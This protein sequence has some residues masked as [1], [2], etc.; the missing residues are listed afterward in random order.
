MC[1]FRQKISF[2]FFKNIFDNHFK[3]SWGLLK[4]Y[5]GFHLVG[6]DGDEYSLSATGDA[7]AQEYRGR[8]VHGDKETYYPR[9]YAVKAIHLLSGVVCGFHHS[10][11]NDEISGALEILENLPKKTIAVYDRFYLSK[12]LLQAHKDHGSHFIFRCK[13]GATFKEIIDFSASSKRA[14]D[15]VLEGINIR[16]IKIKIPGTKK[17]LIFATNLPKENWS[18]KKIEEIYQLRWEC[19][20][21]N[22]DH[23]LSM[24]MEAFH[25]KSINGVLQELYVSFL[26]NNI[27]R[28]EAHENGGFEINPDT[29]IT[30]KTNFKLL[31]EMSF[32]WLKKLWFEKIEGF[33]SLMKTLVTKNISKR[34][35]LSRSYE[36]A[37]KN[38]IKRH[39]N[40]SLVK[41]RA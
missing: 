35:R 26:L 14:M 31:V 13:T 33:V 7:L 36:R 38:G 23:T 17:D 18:K 10:K 39:K 20:T 11:I 28:L 4:S 8:D 32:D 6:I 2:S 16:L 12:R 21:S 27:L 34:K 25:S 41:K 30:R 9:M 37:F 1:V 15:V 5:Q 40:R 22:R 24:N 19:E 29:P 3:N